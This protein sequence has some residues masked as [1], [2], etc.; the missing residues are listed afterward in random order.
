MVLGFSKNVSSQD[1]NKFL[2][3]EIGASQ[4]YSVITPSNALIVPIWSPAGLIGVNYSLKTPK[5]AFDVGLFQ[6]NHSSR[7]QLRSEGS[8]LR[9][10]YLQRTFS[11]FYVPIALN[12]CIEMR[13]G[14]FMALGAGFGTVIL[15]KERG[16][17]NKVVINTP[18][19]AGVSYDFEL[20]GNQANFFGNIAFRFL[21]RDNVYFSAIAKI[22]AGSGSIHRYKIRLREAN[23]T[24]AESEI[25][26]IT[27]KGQAASIRLGVLFLLDE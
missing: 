20:K 4:E 5:L 21:V 6:T 23:M 3:V 19:Y 8:I 18:Q 12:Y 13:N 15:A 16:Q 26:Q 25:Y 22:Q 17:E 2:G 11:N 10:V 27:F 24:N 7:F 1:F 14:S 9:T